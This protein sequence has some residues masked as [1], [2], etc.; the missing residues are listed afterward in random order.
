M[1]DLSVRVVK[2]MIAVA[3]VV[4]VYWLLYSLNAPR[5]VNGVLDVLLIGTFIGSGKRADDDSVA[6]DDRESV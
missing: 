1:E 2:V 3:V 4:G 6:D 5:W